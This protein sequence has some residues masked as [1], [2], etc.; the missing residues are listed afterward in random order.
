MFLGL[1]LNFKP[2]FRV[3]S[4]LSPASLK[5]TNFQKLKKIK[6]KKKLVLSKNR[7]LDL[8]I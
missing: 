3:R 5:K 1:K 8:L 2:K 4:L 6:S 7:T